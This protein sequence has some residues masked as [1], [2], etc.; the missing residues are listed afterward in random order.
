MIVIKW[1]CFILLCTDVYAYVV[2]TV[3]NSKNALGTGIG[4]TVGL[5]AR[6]YALYGLVFCWLLA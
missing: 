2:G 6:I 1:I 5:M 3:A 4:L